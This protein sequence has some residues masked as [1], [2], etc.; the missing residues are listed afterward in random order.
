MMF[1]RNVLRPISPDESLR[2]T[3][4]AIGI[5]LIAEFVLFNTL[6]TIPYQFAYALFPDEQSLEF[7]IAG[8]LCSSVMYVICLVIPFIIFRIAMRNVPK[9]N[10]E[11][12]LRAD[13]GLLLLIPAVAGL[14]DGLVIIDGEISWYFLSSAPTASFRPEAVM[15][16]LDFIY[17]VLVPAF[18]EELFFRGCILENLLPYGKTNALVASAA[19]FAL[20]H[21][22]FKQFL[23]T[24]GAGLLIGAAYLLYKSIWPG[25]IIHLCYNLLAVAEDYMLRMD[26]ISNAAYSLTDAARSA[27]GLLFILL[28]VLYA[29]KHK[30]PGTLSDAPGETGV[31][32]YG[33]N[34]ITPLVITY[35]VLVLAGAV[36]DS[37][38]AL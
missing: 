16:I 31:N 14:S 27:G 29:K 19:A 2:R 32:V 3:A 20:F 23:Y 34:L 37:I 38:F 4:N 24:F 11:F 10:P 30:F 18:F 9:R 17:V 22:N 21:G 36:Y 7:E 13:A 33:K 12:A 26:G 15:I 1:E 5:S 8:S 35:A 28:F 6:F 25:I